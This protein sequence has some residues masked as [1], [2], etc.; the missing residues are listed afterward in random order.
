MHVL[1]KEAFVG[2]LTL[3]SHKVNQLHLALFIQDGQVALSKNMTK[4]AKK[5][6]TFWLQVKNLGM[7]SVR[8]SSFVF[9]FNHKMHFYSI[10]AF[11]PR[12]PTIVGLAQTHNC[13]AFLV[14]KGQEACYLSLAPER[15]EIERCNWCHF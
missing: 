13:L 2:H 1:T 12:P 8:C 9:L 5:K 6:A 11:L 3:F 4:I 15:I 7:V 10:S 14:A